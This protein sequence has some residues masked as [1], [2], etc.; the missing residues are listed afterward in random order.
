MCDVDTFHKLKRIFF[1]VSVLL[2]LAELN[3]AQEID[4]WAFSYIR[5][6]THVYEGI[7]NDLEKNRKIR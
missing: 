6:Y 2:F 1:V 5:P 4:E 3:A 7:K